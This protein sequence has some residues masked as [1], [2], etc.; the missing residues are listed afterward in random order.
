MKILITAPEDTL[1]E[2]IYHL[3]Q[4]GMNLDVDFDLIEKFIENNKPEKII[5]D[6]MSNNEVKQI[7]SNLESDFLSDLGYS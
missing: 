4:A 5:R 2:I 1:V 7:N 3:K 6:E